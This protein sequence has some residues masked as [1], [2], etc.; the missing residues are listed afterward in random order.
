MPPHQCIKFRVLYLPHLNNDNET[1][2]QGFQDT[3]SVLFILIKISMSK[4]VTQSAC[5]DLHVSQERK[6]SQLLSCAQLIKTELISLKLIIEI[7]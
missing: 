1:P 7:D 2:A 4:L 3:L 6:G 5:D